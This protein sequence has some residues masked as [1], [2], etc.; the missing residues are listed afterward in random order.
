MT[1][2]DILERLQKGAFDSIEY[3]KEKSEIC[4]TR[5]Y[6]VMDV[7]AHID[8]EGNILKIDRRTNYGF[9]LG[10]LFGLFGLAFY[11]FLLFLLIVPYQ[12]LVA[13]GRIEKM[14][15]ELKSALEKKANLLS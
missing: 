12:W 5:K 2:K 15:T 8:N 6:G 3:D 1:K 13:S 7:F 9:W 11:P 4:V 10:V 14:R